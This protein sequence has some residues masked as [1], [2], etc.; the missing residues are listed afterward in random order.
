MTQPALP[1]PSRSA[2]LE[3]SATFMP[4]TSMIRY[5][6]MYGPM[7]RWIVRLVGLAV[8][9]VFAC[10]VWHR[11]TTEADRRRYPPPG[12]L[13][14]V[15]GRRLHIQT[16][17]EGSPTVVIS[18]AGAA[19]PLDWTNVLP[20]VAEFA[21]VC[22]YDRAG[23]GWSDPDGGP[24]TSRHIGEE[25]HRLLETADMPRPY[26]LVG[27]S[28]GGIHMRTYTGMF[29]D[30]VVGLVF[31]D[32]SH[33]EQLERMPAESPTSLEGQI[34]VL[35]IAAAI[36]PFGGVRLLGTLGLGAQLLNF[37]FLEPELRKNAR[38]ILY[39]SNLGDLADELESIP[40]TMVQSR[41]L[42]RPLGDMPL[43]VLTAGSANNP[44]FQREGARE[45]W[46][47]MQRELAAL[48]TNSK[49]VIADNSTHY[50]HED[51]PEIVI[52]AIRWVVEEARSRTVS[53]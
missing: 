42:A 33:E 36:A 26:V 28:I 16:R 35:K 13:V 47:E 4:S 15:G 40:E 24:R 32:S 11:A 18:A 53:A 49:H 5:G 25:L 39:W 7:I 10:A 43:A 19:A 21:H 45:I 37:E 51:E 12:R 27:H 14:D 3:P 6:V 48:S 1:E 30:D 9:L 46:F 44:A 41:E 23:S 29:L 50:I 38:A 17:G 22:V 52:D 34:R 8:A 31:V 2:T 20:A